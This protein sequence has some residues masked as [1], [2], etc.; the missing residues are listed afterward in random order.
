MIN[1]GVRVWLWSLVM[2]VNRMWLLL[3]IG[4]GRRLKIVRFILIKIMKV[5]MV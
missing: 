2:V 4:I 1:L 3:R 5:R